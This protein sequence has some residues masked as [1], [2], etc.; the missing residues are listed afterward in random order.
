[1]LAKEGR[2]NTEKKYQD[3]E[4]VLT[5]KKDLLHT[6]LDYNLDLINSILI[7]SITQVLNIVDKNQTIL[8]HHLILL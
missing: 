4:L 5:L 2:I 8:V 3:R 7:A 6:I 1:M